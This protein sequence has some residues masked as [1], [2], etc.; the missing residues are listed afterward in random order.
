MESGVNCF[1]GV[2][3]FVIPV[4]T[5]DAA[6][7]KLIVNPCGLD[8]CNSTLSDFFLTTIFLPGSPSAPVLDIFLPGLPSASVLVV[9]ATAELV[10][11]DFD[12]GRPLVVDATAERVGLDFARG[13]AL[14][15]G[16]MAD[17][18]GLDFNRDSPLVVPAT[19]ELVGLN[20][21]RGPFLVVDAMTEVVG[22]DFDRLPWILKNCGA[23]VFAITTVGFD[24]FLEL[25]V[26]LVCL[27]KSRQWISFRKENDSQE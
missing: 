6:E 24:L 7:G 9:D 17:L 3:E 12:R 5:L 22:L 23:L 16:A 20:F 2:I 8:E 25:I 26:I 27:M 10:R 4:I 15:V 21:A 14:V 11:L 18:L 19:S 13:P 1:S